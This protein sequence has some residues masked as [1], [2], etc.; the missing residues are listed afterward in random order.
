MALTRVGSD[1]LSQA[2]LTA[3][4]IRAAQLC[5]VHYEPARDAVLR[6]HP[7]NFAVKR[8][9]LITQAE[10]AKTI[11]GAT[12]ADPVVIT[13]VAHGYSDGD[14]VRIAS[15]GGMTEI[16]SRNFTIDVSSVDA[17][18]LVD[19]DGSTHT[20]YTTGGTSTKIP[21]FE[22]DYWYALPSDSLRI[23]Q[24]DDGL[25]RYKVEKNRILTSFDTAQVKYIYQVTDATLFEAQ[26]VDVLAERIAAEICIGLT[27]NANM[28]ERLWQVYASK[29]REARGTDAQ[30][31]TP[32]GLD[33]D[34]WINSRI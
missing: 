28:A 27:D 18:S 2:Q 33:A 12:A 29:L 26:F 13:A 15:V 20:A 14:R 4:A 10:T 11:T 22:F 30:E 9:T 31:D 3:D 24:V 23:L 6:A 32:D 25:Y 8:T 1:L 34:G 19:E 21:A 17:F 7:W 16:N 5:N